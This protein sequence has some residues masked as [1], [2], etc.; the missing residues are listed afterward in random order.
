M[1]TLTSP[2]WMPPAKAVVKREGL[3][4]PANEN[5]WSGP[6]LGLLAALAVGLPVLVAVLLFTEF[7]LLEETNSGAGSVVAPVLESEPT[8]PSDAEL[9]AASDALSLGPA[10]SQ[11]V[12]ASLPPPADRVYVVVPGDVLRVALR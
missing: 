4:R 12:E 2:S 7:S 1:S 10:A 6:L 8:G 11:T 3:G 5:V 9:P